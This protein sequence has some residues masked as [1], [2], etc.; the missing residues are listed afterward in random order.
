MCLLSAVAACLSAR[1]R[2]PIEVMGRG[3]EVVTVSADLGGSGTSAR[4]LRLR[5]HGL[6][7]GTQGSVRVN[8]G[9]WIALN[10]STLRLTQLAR[11]YGGL[12][13][14]FH[15]LDATLEL[16]AGA[17]REGSNEISFRFNGT[18]GRSSGYRVLEL[19]FEDGT[20]RALLSSSAFVE[21]DPD[22]WEPPLSAGAAIAEG[23]RLWRYASLDAP[24]RGPIQAKCADCH[25]Q[26]GRDLRYF[27]YSNY[28]IRQRARFHGLSAQQGE[29]IA[30]YIRSLD[31]P[32][33]GRPWNPPYQ[34]GPWLDSK[35]VEEWAAG[36]G[37]DAVLDADVETYDY[38]PADVYPA[39]ANLN[40]RETPLALQLPDW[41]HWLPEVHPLD[42]WG[43][44]FANHGLYKSYLELRSELR[45]GDAAAYRSAREELK[46]WV[47]DWQEFT[48]PRSEGV[49][50]TAERRRAV[51]S[52][53][54]WKLVK[55]WEL[56]Q[57]N[58]LEGLGRSV[59]DHSLAEDRAWFSAFPF[60]VSPNMQHLPAGPGLANGEDEVRTYLSFI[61]YHV[62]LILNNS[63]GEQYGTSPVDWPY[64]Y[65][66]I[67]DL[68]NDGRRQQAGL[69]TLWLIKALQISNHGRGPERGVNGWM[70]Q[71]NDIS[72]PLHP[73]WRYIWEGVS[74][75]LQATSLQALTQSWLNEVSKFTP[76]QY[77]DGN[78]ASRSE[79][80]SSNSPDGRFVDRIWYTIPRLRHRGVSPALTSQIIAWA[81]TVWPNA[82]WRALETATCYTGNN[83]VVCRL[84]TE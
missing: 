24:G 83:Q 52:T 68:S 2:L 20:G 81:S 9:S 39:T 31:A 72:R 42:A 6:N 10:E 16:A 64:V 75:S 63:N 71:V 73:S 58:R 14:G 62:Q 45:P 3:G 15:T 50:W 30:S 48:R 56:M 27:N 19:N 32:N 66:F 11:D 25:A 33:P 70:P 29:Q 22:Q 35:P 54:L 13:G 67:K 47:V 18:D 28:A 4:R 17:A 59:F 12:G 80:P 37:I 23:E 34:P 36:A 44:A 79:T 76:Q 78:W 55:L 41:N 84:S 69:Q 5:L 60:F 61:W 65:G 8:G 40:V 26:D 82:N 77:Y 53:T 1:I 38:L 7:Y 49:S 51:Y 74:P 21:E 43:D 57:E 46:L